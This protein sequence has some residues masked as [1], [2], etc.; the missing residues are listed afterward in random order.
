MYFVTNQELCLFG[1]EGKITLLHAKELD[2]I[3]CANHNL[4]VVVIHKAQCVKSRGP[5]CFRSVAT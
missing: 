1:D 3:G 5:N 2:L 4:I